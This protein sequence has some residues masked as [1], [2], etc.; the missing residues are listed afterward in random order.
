MKPVRTRKKTSMM[1]YTSHQGAPASNATKVNLMLRQFN[2]SLLEF[3]RDLCKSFP[4]VEGFR[5][6]YAS[7]NL[8]STI[9][10]SMMQ[11]MFNRYCSQYKDQIVNHDDEF[12]L[13]KDYKEEMSAAGESIEIVSMIKDVWGTIEQADKDNIWRH[14]EVLVAID[15]MIEEAKKA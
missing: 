10:P 3:I 7:S 14:M 9:N 13:S 4:K 15:Y 2:Q 12:F 8:M 1:D 11:G 5:R 6:A